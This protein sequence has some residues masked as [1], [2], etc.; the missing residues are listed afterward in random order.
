MIN[1]NHLRRIFLA[2]MGQMGYVGSSGLINHLG[3]KVNLGSSSI[4]HVKCNGKFGLN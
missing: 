3:A 2:L 4:D 1:L